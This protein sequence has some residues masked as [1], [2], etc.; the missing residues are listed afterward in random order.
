M[1]RR[2]GRCGCSTGCGRPAHREAPT[3]ALQHAGGA[4]TLQGQHRG[5]GAAPRPDAAHAP[6]RGA[7]LKAST[8]RCRA[9]LRHRLEHAAQGGLVHHGARLGKQACEHPAP[10]RRLQRAQ[11][12]RVQAALGK[13]Q[14]APG[15][16]RQLAPAAHRPRPPAARTRPAAPSPRWPAAREST[17][18][19]SRRTRTRNRRGS[20][21]I[22]SVTKPAPCS[23]RKASTCFARALQ[24]RTD[25]RATPA[26]G[27]LP[28][29]C[30]AVPRASRISSVSA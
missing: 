13:H 16:L 27:C 2:G 14:P 23:R 24:Q 26:P 6:A 21:F 1:S 17:G 22:G 15:R 7:K 11:A 8:Q 5:L 10:Q 19:T 9:A 12:H 28:L 3:R 4:L 18:S 29:P 25:D 20:S 30:S